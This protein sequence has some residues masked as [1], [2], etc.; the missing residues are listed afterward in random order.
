MKL[1]SQVVLA[2]LLSVSPDGRWRALVL[3]A[4]Q[5]R[6]ATL[7]QYKVAGDRIAFGCIHRGRRARARQC[8]ALI[9]EGR[10]RRLA[11]AQARHPADCES[12]LEAGGQRMAPREQPASFATW[13]VSAI[14][15]VDGRAIG[16]GSTGPPV[17]SS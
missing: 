4:M 13:H 10:G 2:I 11:S 16:S 6:L 9:A 12:K 3:S 8:G 14:A 17:I 1:W 7:I 5:H 15:P